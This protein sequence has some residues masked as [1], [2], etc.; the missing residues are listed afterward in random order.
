M[1]ARPERVAMRAR[2]PCRRARLSL[3]GW[4]VRFMIQI[5]REKIYV[6]ATTRV[7]ASDEKERDYT[8]LSVLR[9]T[10]TR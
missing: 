9:A 7:G 3:L 8:V 4:K 2:K 10:L 1:I 5:P 6:G